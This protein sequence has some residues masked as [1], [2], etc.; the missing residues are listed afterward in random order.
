MSYILLNHVALNH[1]ALN[2]VALNHVALNHVAYIFK[3][4]CP[5]CGNNV[6]VSGGAAD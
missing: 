5:S 2:H 1:V 4:S 3:E 6:F